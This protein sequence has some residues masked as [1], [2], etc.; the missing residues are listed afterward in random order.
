MIIKYTISDALI[1]MN[2]IDGDDDELAM[3][4]KTEFLMRVSK[5][6]LFFILKL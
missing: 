5:D 2:P 1:K 4:L 6:N 3:A